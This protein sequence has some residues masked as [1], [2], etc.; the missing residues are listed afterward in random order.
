MFVIGGV[1]LVVGAESLISGASRFATRLGVSPMTIGLTIV[2]YGTS[3]PEFVVSAK[4]SLSGASGVALGNVMGSNI[5]N[6]ALILAISISIRP[7][8]VQSRLIAREIPFLL[9][10]SVAT[11]LMLLDGLVARWEG[12]LLFLAGTTFTWALFREAA[13]SDRQQRTTAPQDIVQVSTKGIVGD[14]TRI[15]VGLVGLYLGGAW[16]VD[17]A[18]YLAKILGVSDQTIGLTLVALGTSLPELLT[19]IVALRKG[20]HEIGLGNIVG[21]NIFNLTLVLGGASAVAPVEFSGGLGWIDVALALLV[22][23]AILPLRKTDYTISRWRGRALLV[24]YC[25]YIVWLFSV[26][27]P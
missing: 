14:T 3:L 4:A 9:A 17:G 18:V 25:A 11:A 6:F 24:V 12:L 23:L 2:A 27:Q 10:V 5:C 15:A 16:F 1:L 7:L 13:H 20:E 21:S 26:K 8:H 19:T 22:P